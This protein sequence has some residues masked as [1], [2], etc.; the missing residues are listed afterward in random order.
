MCSFSDCNAQIEIFHTKKRI[1]LKKNRKKV[2]F[3]KL[4]S[5][6]EVKKD[7]NENCK[8]VEEIV[9]TFF[10]IVSHSRRYVEI[11]KKKIIYKQ[12]I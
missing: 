3:Q 4:I 12:A 11:V 9:N 1:M 10:R 2:L 7:K 8:L 6:F 5:F